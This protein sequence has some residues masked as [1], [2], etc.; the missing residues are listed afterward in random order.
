MMRHRHLDYPED[1]PVTELGD[2]ALDDLLDRGDLGDWQP[3]VAAIAADP[4]GDLADRV[5]ALCDAS[6]RQ[7]TS[8]LWRAWIARRRAMAAPVSVRV[9]SLVELRRQ[10]HLTQSMLAERIG[11][12]QSDLSKLERRSDW[13]VSTLLAVCSGLGLRAS[14]LLEGE[15]GFVATLDLSGDS[16]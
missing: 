8:P 15:D 6:P 3:L 10:H 4:L 1:T 11:M 2:A 13:K 16:V 5:L 14:L 7:G 12:S 9:S